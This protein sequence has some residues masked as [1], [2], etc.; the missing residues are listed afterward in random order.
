MFVTFLKSMSF[1][2]TLLF[3]FFCMTVVSLGVSFNKIICDIIDKL[4][5]KD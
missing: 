4:D 1:T 5:K 3:I 2:D